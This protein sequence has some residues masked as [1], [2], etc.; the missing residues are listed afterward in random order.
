LPC[1]PR[2]QV[3]TQWHIHNPKCFARADPVNTS[4]R[5]SLLL[6][7][8]TQVSRRATTNPQGSRPG[9]CACLAFGCS[10]ELPVR[11]RAG[12]APATVKHWAAH[13][14]V[15][16]LV[17]LITTT[18]QWEPGWEPSVADIRPH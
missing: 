13:C 5:V 14:Q 3:N 6:R 18:A 7:V 2:G 4:H 10:A 11:T 9:R 16:C 8:P 17:A 1:Q 15:P 12:T